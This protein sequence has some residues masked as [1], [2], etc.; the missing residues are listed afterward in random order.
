MLTLQE[1]HILLDAYKEDLNNY[2]TLLKEQYSL[3]EKEVRQLMHRTGFKKFVW[4]Y[5]RELYQLL[6]KKHTI[7]NNHH[8][9]H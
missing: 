6:V 1:I 4:R 3:N 2:D 5:N 7:K 8:I 9:N